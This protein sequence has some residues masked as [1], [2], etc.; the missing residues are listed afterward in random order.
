MALFESYER[1]IDK[2]NGVLAR[3]RHRLALRS[4]ATICKAKGFD[5]YEIVKGVQPI[6]FENAVLGLLRSARPSPSEEG[7]ARP[8]PKLP[9][10]SALA[11]RPSASPAPSPSDRKVGLGHGNLG[12]MLL[13]DETKCFCL[14]GRPRVLCRRRRRH[15]HRPQRQQGPQGAPARHPQRPGQGRRPDHQPHQRLHLCRRPSLTITPAS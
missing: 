4:A 10:P 11:C 3:V 2:I 15:R 6:A 7:R 1:R 12:A 8:P 5:P 14:P 9:R 13:R